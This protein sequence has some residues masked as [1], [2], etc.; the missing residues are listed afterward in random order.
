MP[1]ANIKFVAADITHGAANI[2]HGAA[3]I[4]NWFYGLNWGKLRFPGKSEDNFA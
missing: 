2:L 1:L 4:F 3:V